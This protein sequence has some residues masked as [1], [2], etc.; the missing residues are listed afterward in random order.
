MKNKWL[1]TGVLLLV[2]LALAG[3]GSKSGHDGMNM[4]EGMMD[5]LSVDLSWSPEQV[6]VGEEVSIEVNVTQKDKKVEKADEVLIEIAKDGDT[7]AHEKVAAENK[8]EGK[9]ILHK[10]FESEGTYSITSHVTYGPQH[11]M[12]TKKLT[13]SK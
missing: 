11:T 2:I 7:A 5:P 3:C 8:G 6:K 9:Y 12:P 4:D 13:V 10:T 1:L